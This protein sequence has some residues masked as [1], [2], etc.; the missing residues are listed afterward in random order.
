DLQSDQFPVIP[1]SVPPIAPAGQ[2]PPGAEPTFIYG[3]AFLAWQNPANA[4]TW[5]LEEMDSADRGRLLFYGGAHP[6]MDASGGKFIG[7]YKKLQAHPR[8]ELR[9]WK[10]FSELIEEYAA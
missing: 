2:P 7:L 3:G 4:I 1:F 6:A 10:P 9:G 5:L 8:V